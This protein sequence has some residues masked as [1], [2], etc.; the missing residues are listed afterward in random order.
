MNNLDFDDIGYNFLVGSD[1]HIYEGA[2][3]HTE[4]AHT[5]G[6]NKKS[7]GI[8]FIGN[9]EESIPPR[10]MLEAAQ[11]F[12][13]CA[14]NIGELSTDY[15]LIGGRQVVAMASPGA[16]LYREIRRWPHFTRNP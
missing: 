4:G 13:Q 5:Y 3:F 7:L 10:I 2:G 1:G 12:L 6:Y 14:V 15:K 9:F 8:G 16:Q 11:K